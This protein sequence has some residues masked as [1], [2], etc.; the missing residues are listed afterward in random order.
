M[1]ETADEVGARLNTHEAVCA[2]R[3]ANLKSGIEGAQKS[4][5]SVKKVLLGVAGIVLTQVL[6][7]T[8][9]LLLHTPV[10]H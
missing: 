5:D 8:T 10:G 6:V 7:V 3:Y 9:Y 2:E 1:T 4:V